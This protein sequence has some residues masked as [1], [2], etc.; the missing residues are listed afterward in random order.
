MEPLFVFDEDVTYE[1]MY[2]DPVKKKVDRVGAVQTLVARDESTTREFPPKFIIRK[3]DRS[4]PHEKI[5]Q[6]ASAE[7]TIF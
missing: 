6:S 7:G 3:I 2:N 1:I 4:T 5:M